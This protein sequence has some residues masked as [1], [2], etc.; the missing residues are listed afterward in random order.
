[1]KGYARPDE[2]GA[3]HLMQ[4]T[5]SLRHS[6][7]VLLAGLA[8]PYGSGPTDDDFDVAC[9]EFRERERERRRRAR[10]R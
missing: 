8:V 10:E 6:R 7:L 2:A 5:A 1:M 9:S 4:Q 3:R